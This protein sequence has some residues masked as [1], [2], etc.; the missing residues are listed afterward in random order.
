MDLILER[1]IDS[2]PAEEIFENLALQIEEAMS[3]A[4]KNQLAS[5]A[6]RRR[7]SEQC[8]A[9]AYLMPDKQMYPI[10]NP[11][12]C[13]YDCH[14]LS[15]ALLRVSKFIGS[16]PGYR[17]AALKARAIMKEKG[18]PIKIGVKVEGID[19]LFEIEDLITILL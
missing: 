14:L 6:I 13:D 19:Q 12:T 3:P 17:E 2:S 5:P 4:I 15:I 9:K 7:M 18:C 16:K 1:T 10:V 8:G 11:S